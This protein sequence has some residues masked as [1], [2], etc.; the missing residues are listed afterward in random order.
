MKITFLGTS[1]GIPSET[2]FCSST[3]IEI[4]EAVYLIDGGAPVADLLLRRGVDLN[5]IKAIFTTHIHADHTLGLLP[6]ISLLNWT[7]MCQSAATDIFMTEEAGIEAFRNV[8]LTVDKK[9][10]DARLRFRKTEEG[11]FYSDDNLTVTAVP[12][13]HM[14][15]GAFPT[16]SLIIDAEG[17][18]VVFTGDLHW[19]DAADFPLPAKEEPSDAIVC[20]MAHFS[21]EAI[22]PI[23]KGCPTK[24][25]LF[26]HV[27]FKYEENMNAIREAGDSLGFP[28]RAVE[29]G[30][31][32]EI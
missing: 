11:V 18:R 29:D 7:R 25:V 28:I 32:A 8:I 5:R 6:L 12:T 4:G 10:D 23:L 14:Q 30:D 26:N 21:Y 15:N 31:E 19:A 1:H 17:R 9:F 16:Y 13:K 22:F 2:R 20:E 27:F 24:Q 3:M